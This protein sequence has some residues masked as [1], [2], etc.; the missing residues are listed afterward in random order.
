MI[1]GC[2]AVGA[3]A[4]STYVN[5]NA[6][7]WFGEPGSG[8][9]ATNDQV[10]ISFDTNGGVLKNAVYVYD[11]VQG[12]P[13][14]TSEVTGIW[15]M[16]PYNPGST[17]QTPGTSITLPALTPP[18]GQQFDGWYCYGDTQ[19]YGANTAWTIPATL[20]GNVTAGHVIYFR[21]AFSPATVEEDSVGKI[22]G[23]LAKV[24]GAIIGILLYKGDTE[25]G[26]ALVEKMLAGIVG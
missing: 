20:N 16:V 5:Q 19:T 10:I 2:F 24:F 11:Q 8:C 9:A 23:V 22:L 1:C 14:L 18:A 4:A 12:K 6:E 7:G 26:V 13:V 21:A 15:C 3:S 17:E 25:A